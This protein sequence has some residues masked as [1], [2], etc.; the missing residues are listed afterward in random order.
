MVAI[1]LFDS[2]AGRRLQQVQVPEQNMFSMTQPV[3]I[4][5]IVN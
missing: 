4:K 3:K 2:L 5:F 1:N